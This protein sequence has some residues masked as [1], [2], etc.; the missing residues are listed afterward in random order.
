MIPPAQ[1]TQTDSKGE[2]D[3]NQE[4]LSCS[5]VSRLFLIFEQ[6]I[7]IARRRSVMRINAQAGVFAGSGIIESEE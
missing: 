2:R 3:Q 1:I 4:N 6:V 7:Q 5:G